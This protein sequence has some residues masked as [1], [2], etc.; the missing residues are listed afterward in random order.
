[1]DTSRAPSQ[2]GTA[3][4]DGSGRLSLWRLVPLGGRMSP[5]NKT[6]VEI[7]R[8]PFFWGLLIAFGLL[9]WHPVLGIIAFVSFGLAVWLK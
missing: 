1:M 3:D 9:M 4:P 8:D 6:D 7:L 2:Y 5:F